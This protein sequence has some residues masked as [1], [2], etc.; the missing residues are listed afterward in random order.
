[1][2]NF[3]VALFYYS[4]IQEQMRFIESH[5][6]THE[7]WVRINGGCSITEWT[8]WIRVVTEFSSNLLTESRVITFRLVMC[9]LLFSTII[10]FQNKWL[11]TV[12]LMNRTKR[13][14]N[15]GHWN[16]LRGHWVNQLNWMSD[17]WTNHWDSFQPNQPFHMNPFYNAESFWRFWKRA[18]STFFKI[19][20]VFHGT[21]LLLWINFKHFSNWNKY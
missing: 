16:L 15:Y 13:L 9:W 1:M 18:T 12:L 11:L 10:R 3:L 17:L 2:C 20:F 7:L 4:W 19:Y 14:M 21:L 8:H 5:K 6:K